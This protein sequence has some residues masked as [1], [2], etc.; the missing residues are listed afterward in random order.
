MLDGHQT[1]AVTHRSIAFWFWHHVSA[2]SQAVIFYT[3]TYTDRGQTDT[4]ST[5]FGGQTYTVDYNYDDRG[6]MDEVVYPSGKKTEYTFDDRSSLDT[7]TMPMAT[8]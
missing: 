1:S 6:R 5:T 8:S 7:I 3:M 2:R 4:Q